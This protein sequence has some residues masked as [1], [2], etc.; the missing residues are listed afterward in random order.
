MMLGV[1]GPGGDP[2]KVGKAFAEEL[3]REFG[4]TPSQAE[5]VQVGEWPGYLV[6][7]TDE[8]A[9]EAMNIHFL[10]VSHGET[11]YQLIAMAPVN[12]PA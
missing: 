1:H 11:V 6:T 10:W 7:L 5:Q 3:T 8:S 4:T 12:T 2:V 9:S